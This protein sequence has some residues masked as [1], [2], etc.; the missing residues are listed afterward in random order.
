MEVN[1]TANVGAFL[2]LF[3]DL[4]EYRQVSH[5]RIVKPRGIDY[6]KV[7]SKKT[8]R[9]FFAVGCAF[10]DVSDGGWGTCM[11]NSSRFL[12]LLESVTPSTGF[13]MH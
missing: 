3:C 5:W 8:R 10:G 9:V 4:A 2:Q 7:R 11:Y 6:S 12:L 1:D 13:P